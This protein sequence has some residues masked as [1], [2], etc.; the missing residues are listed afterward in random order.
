MWKLILG[1]VIFLVGWGI[2]GYFMYKAG[3]KYIE[4]EDNHEDNDDDV[5]H[6]DPT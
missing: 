4:H 5:L 3:D 2:A 1:L 6:I